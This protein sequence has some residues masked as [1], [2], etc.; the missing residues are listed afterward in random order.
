MD[1]L[2]VKEHC[3]LSCD[4]AKNHST[5]RESHSGQAVGAKAVAATAVHDP[6]RTGRQVRLHLATKAPWAD[7]VNDAV[8]RLRA[9]AVPS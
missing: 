6:A 9:L 7:L 5:C 8:R 4:L 3:P 1:R 2:N